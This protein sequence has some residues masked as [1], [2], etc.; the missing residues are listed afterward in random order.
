MEKLFYIKDVRLN[1]YEMVNK[2]IV[3]YKV[4]DKIDLSKTYFQK[5]EFSLNGYETFDI[6]DY[7][8]TKCSA[9]KCNDYKASVVSDANKK[10]LKIDYES[11]IENINIFSYLLNLRY[12]DNGKQ[13]IV[14]SNDIKNITPSNYQDDD[15]LIEV[16]SEV[17]DSS[18]IEFVFN[19]WGYQFLISN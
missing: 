2:D 14:K 9:N 11:N 12:Y 18:V 3:E 5:G 17:T 1:P 4:K 7:T 10:I 13:Y 16:P 15:V 19:L 6:I 8:Y